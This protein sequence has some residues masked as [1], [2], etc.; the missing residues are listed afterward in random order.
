[1]LAGC[2]GADEDHAATTRVTVAAAPVEHCVAA[3]SSHL[4]LCERAGAP[5]ES[6]ATIQRRYGTAWRVVA[7]TPPLP[8]ARRMPPLGFWRKAWLS[9]DGETVLAEWSG[10]C[11]VPHAFFVAAKNGS[12]RVVTGERDWT[13]SPES[14]ALGWSPGGLARVR[15]PKGLC[16]GS[17]ARPGVYLVDPGT[18]K[19]TRAP[20]RG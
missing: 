10:E 5:Y 14:I 9:P 20:A 3:R 6:N 7:R 4:R 13:T 8:R 18:G 19:L 11:E 2:G 16:G 17:A 15:L 1:M 12:M